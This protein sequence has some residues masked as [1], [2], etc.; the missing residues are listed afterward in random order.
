MAG[1]APLAADCRTDMLR[2]APARLRDEMADRQLADL[3]QLGRELWEPEHLVERRSSSSGNRPLR[4]IVR[5]RT[6]TGFPMDSAIPTGRPPDGHH[7]PDPRGGCG[8]R[9]PGGDGPARAVGEVRRRLGLAAGGHVLR[10]RPAGSRPPRARD[11]G[12]GNL[13]LRGPGRGETALLGCVYIDRPRTTRRRARTP[14]SRGGSSTTQ[15]APTWNARSASSSR[16]GSPRLG[17]SGQCTMR[18]SVAS[19]GTPRR[20]ARRAAARS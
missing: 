16:A 11:R 3:H 10:S 1:L 18:P 20:L 14:S 19:A 12:A 2:P 6:W 5:S 13:Q 15:W 9:L 17:A 8:H 7:L 4:M